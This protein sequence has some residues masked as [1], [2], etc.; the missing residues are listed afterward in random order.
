[1]KCLLETHIPKD[2]AEFRNILPIPG[3]PEIDIQ[4]VVTEE[5]SIK[6]VQHRII[7]ISVFY[8][9]DHILYT[10]EFVTFSDIGLKV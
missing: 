3:V 9:S 4:P 2:G 8:V 5:S 1:L 7:Q 6:L 10:S